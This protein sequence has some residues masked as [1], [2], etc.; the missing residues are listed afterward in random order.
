MA[1]Q[2]TGRVQE[3]LSR[4]GVS[5]RTLRTNRDRVRDLIRQCVDRGSQLPVSSLS[6]GRKEGK[7]GNWEREAAVMAQ[8][9]VGPLQ[10]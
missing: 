8:S 9:V 2:L 4:G 5:A 1:G 3:I 10:R 7:V 6:S